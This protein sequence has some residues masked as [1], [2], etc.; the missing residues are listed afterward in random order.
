[1]HYEPENVRHLLHYASSVYAD[2]AN[3]LLDIN[4]TSLS[5]L[6]RKHLRFVIFWSEVR[7]GDS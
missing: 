5:V 3:V 4:L 7:S 6:A 1:V 2:N